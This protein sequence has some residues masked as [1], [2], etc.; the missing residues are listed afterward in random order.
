MAKSTEKMKY[1]K[2]LNIEFLKEKDPTKQI[3]HL[4]KMKQ[5]KLPLWGE[6]DFFKVV[7]PKQSKRLGYQPKPKADLG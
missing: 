2:D 1:L 5:F 7:M 4:E 3:S 6:Q